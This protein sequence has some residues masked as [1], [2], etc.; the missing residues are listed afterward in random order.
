VAFS[1]PS[2]TAG[3][4]PVP[5]LPY[6]LASF[7]KGGV[8]ALYHDA[9]LTLSQH[10]DAIIPVERIKGP[11]LLISGKQ[12]KLWPSAVMGDQIMARL[13]QA[14]IRY[15]RQHLS[16]DNAGHAAFGKPAAL[17]VTIP[18]AMIAAAGGTAE[19]NQAARVDSWPKTL[20][21][22]HQASKTDCR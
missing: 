22:L 21:F 11:V 9:L 7:E 17:G 4:A 2:W 5:F 20:A 16:Y 15:A 6:A 19:G 3:G 10:A 8:Y 13:A 1:Q 14:K 18:P 12:D